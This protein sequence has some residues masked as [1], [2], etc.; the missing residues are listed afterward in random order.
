MKK[1]FICFFLFLSLLSSL[2]LASQHT[3]YV[4]YVLNDVLK[5]LEANS[6]QQQKRQ[7]VVNKYYRLID[8]EWNAKMA[9]GR[10]Y[11]ELTANEQGEYLKEYTRFI[12]YSWLPKL[13]YDRSL[14]LKFTVHQEG[15][16]VGKQD[17]NVVIDMMVPDGT[18]YSTALRIRCYKENDCKV[19]N[20]NIE[21]V[22]LALSYRAQFSSYIEE[23]GNKANSII[24]F[25]K[26]KNSEFKK[27]VDFKLPID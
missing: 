6:S 24:A 9:L 15:E 16:K 20:V 25:L 27:N 19:L 10:P 18:K 5:S 7:T 14:N 13:N 22:D 1:F 21:G 26:Q 4:Q 23:H 11:K 8:F 12:A 3:Q 17:E 2:S